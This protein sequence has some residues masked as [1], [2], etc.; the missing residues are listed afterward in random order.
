MAALTAYGKLIRNK[1]V[2]MN[3]PPP[4]AERM[5]L[6]QRIAHQWGTKKRDVEYLTFS[7][8]GAKNMF[9]LELA[10]H[11]ARVYHNWEH[12]YQ[13]DTSRLAMAAR[14]HWGFSRPEVF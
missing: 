1:L 14:N 2:A 8:F 11:I 7:R 13:V 6:E 3:V 9:G 10:E 12:C 5:I 4:A